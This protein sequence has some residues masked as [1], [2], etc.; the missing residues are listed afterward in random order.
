VRV[1]IEAETIFQ[2][3]S[4]DVRRFQVYNELGCTY[5]DKAFLLKQQSDTE[6]ALRQ[7]GIA[8]DYLKESIEIAKGEGAE[9]KYPVYF[10]DACEDLAQVYHI[11]GNQREANK[12]MESAEKA[13]PE[14]YK[15]K[16]GSNPEQ[17]L[18]SD[19]FEDF[20][21]QLGKIASL[22]GRMEF[23][24]TSL[25]RDL[26][27]SPDNLRNAI[28]QYALA[29][30]YFGRFLER[31]IGEEHK[32]LYPSYRPQLANHR[33]FVEQLYDNLKDINRDDLKYIRDEL[34]PQLK[35]TYRMKHS[36]T[37]DLLD[38][39]LGFALQMMNVAKA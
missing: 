15:L 18:P 10:V 14:M 19:C 35:E 26:K 28:R 3:V 29:A 21:Q 20:W 30:A 9:R 39:P 12:W 23:G 11:I 16:E 6:S 34:L 38:E 2:E 22:R 31:P 32:Y 37:D 27:H 7:A 1:L 33:R 8:T 5:R 13:I 4:E 17:V 24:R 36:W 25:P